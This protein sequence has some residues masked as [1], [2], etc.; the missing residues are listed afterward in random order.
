MLVDIYS[1]TRVQLIAICGYMEHAVAV[2]L[3]S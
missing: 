3:N 2:V 1:C